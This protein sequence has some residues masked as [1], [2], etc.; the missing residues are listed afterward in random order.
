MMSHP[1]PPSR[2]QWLHRFGGGLG[3]FALADLLDQLAAIGGPRAEDET[4]LALFSKVVVS[5]SELCS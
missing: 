4:D 3:A 1:F 5:M 2:R